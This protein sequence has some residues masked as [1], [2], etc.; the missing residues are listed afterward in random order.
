MC[1]DDGVLQMLIDNQILTGEERLKIR[2]HL[3][4]CKECRQR[5]EELKRN[6]QFI[7]K[8]MKLLLKE[9][10]E[11]NNGGVLGMLKNKKI[12][13]IVASIM[14][15]CLIIFT[16]LGRTLADAIK[17]FRVQS[18]EPISLNIEDLREIESKFYT[19]NSKNEIDLK[20]FGKINLQVGKE[21]YYKID[22]SD[23]NN[24]SHDVVGILS[25]Y[26]IDKEYIFNISKKVQSESLTIIE[27]PDINFEATLDVDNIN[28]LIK[29]YNKEA[30]IPEKL[31]N[32]TFKVNLKGILNINFSPKEGKLDYLTISIAKL[33]Q[34][35]VPEGVEIDELVNAF[36]AIPFIPDSIKRQI[37]SI[38]DYTNTLPFPVDKQYYDYQKV[39]VHNYDALYLRSK[40]RAEGSLIWVDKNNNIKFIILDSPEVELNTL[41]DIAL[42]IEK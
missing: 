18:I 19:I 38:N 9:N 25:K 7:N 27:Q 11:N 12:I 30:A 33:P 21:G 4:V 13:S 26:G 5:Y 37:L 10:N 41:M 2:K 8:K 22:I 23:F 36:K 28:K 20:Q 31:D 17:I 35:E 42:E 32:K 3:L 39:K 1:Y 6:Q 40:Q 24:T 34:F 15:L 16:P 14:V 29:M